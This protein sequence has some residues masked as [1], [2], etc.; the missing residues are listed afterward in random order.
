MNIWVWVTT[1]RKPD[2]WTSCNLSPSSDER[3]LTSDGWYYIKWIPQMKL[4]QSWINKSKTEKTIIFT[5][6]NLKWWWK[7]KE[8]CDMEL[9]NKYLWCGQ[10]CD[11]SCFSWRTIEMASFEAT[12]RLQLRS[13]TQHRPDWS[14]A[15]CTTKHFPNNVQKIRRKMTSLKRRTNR[16]VPFT[17]CANKQASTR[18][19]SVWCSP[20]T[21]RQRMI[22]VTKQL[23]VPIHHWS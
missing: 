20:Q 17:T 1:E 23:P 14:Q 5:T 10:K 21:F 22:T 4:S 9:L 19:R 2:L 11:K 16:S 6:K 8:S 12:V 7:N 3:I 13:Q 15:S 18:V